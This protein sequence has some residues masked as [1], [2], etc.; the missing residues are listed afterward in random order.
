MTPAQRKR[1]DEI[2]KKRVC[3]VIVLRK[4]LETTAQN[5]HPSNKRGRKVLN[6]IAEELMYAAKWTHP[7]LPYYLTTR[8]I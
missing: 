5:I 3:E 6:D 7:D 4:V 1:C 8:K 2:L